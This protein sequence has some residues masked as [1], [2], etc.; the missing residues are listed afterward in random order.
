VTETW[1]VI[2]GV[3]GL[4]ALAVVIYRRASAR[5]GRAPVRRAALAAETG[6]EKRRGRLATPRQYGREA[7]QAEDEPREADSL[8]DS[9]ETVRAMLDHTSV[10]IF[11][12]DMNG[13]ITH[14]NRRTS[15]MFQYTP[16]EL[17]RMTYFD[18]LSVPGRGAARVAY[19]QQALGRQEPVD[20]EQ[21]YRRSDGS[22]FW[23]GLACRFVHGSS[24][25]EDGLVCVITDISAGHQ[26]EDALRLK[27]KILYAISNGVFVLDPERRIVDVNPALSKITGYRAEDII[28]RSIRTFASDQQSEGFYDEICREL[29]ASD[30]WEGDVKHRRKTGESYRL[31][32]SISAVRDDRTRLVGFVGV[33]QDI[34]QRHRVERQ[35]RL[36]AFS[37]PLT[38]LANRLNFFQRAAD[39][40]ALARR[41]GRRMAFLFIDLDH[42]KRIN[43]QHGHEAG[44]FIL[45]AVARRLRASVRE[46]DIVCR[47]GGDEFVILLPEMEG[48]DA[49][50]PLAEKLLQRIEE[51]CDY[52]GRQLAVSACVGIA[53]YPDH[54]EN[55]DTL[56]RRA[57]EAMYFAKT[58][59]KD[60]V[61]L[62]KPQQERP[63]P[64]PSIT[65]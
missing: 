40:F 15:E 18:F 13:N 61:C 10:A 9:G 16:Q 56:I 37:D 65:K 55:V 32:L 8:L 31:A 43:D 60:R 42:F 34:T 54:G 36:L 14:A 59:T 26:N 47:L 64:E 39:A 49:L 2:T 24:A 41:H 53:V 25:D 57:D 19:Q 51:P 27:T 44:D 33:F 21:L 22:E 1:F 17:E 20:T 46:S 5:D 4:I 50:R 38:R 7:D 63:A 62:A 12:T 23:G 45:K 52:K 58:E 35:I 11:R 29:D 6:D 48:I 28:G 3:I 30:A